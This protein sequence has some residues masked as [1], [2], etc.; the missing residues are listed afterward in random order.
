M[1]RKAAGY[2][3]EVAVVGGGPAGLIAAVALAAAGAETVLIAPSPGPDRRTTALLD[4]SVKALTAL[5]VWEGLA[6]RASAL[7]VLRLVDATRRLIRA[8]EVAFDCA[9]LGLEAFGYNIEN[10]ILRDGLFAAARA[11]KRLRRVDAAVTEVAPDDT[12]VMLRSGA[13]DER[14]RLLVAADGRDSF[15]RKAA[16]IATSGRKLPQSALAL[17][18]RHSRPHDN[19]STEFHTESGPFTLVPLP[20]RRSSLVWVVR[21]EE[22]DTLMALDDMALGGEVERR[23]HSI[24]GKMQVEAG[25]GV[26]PLA[27][28]I[29]ERFAARRIVLVGEAGHVLPPIGAQGLNLGIRDAALI[30]ELVAD[31]RRDGA[32]V[33]DVCAEYDRRRQSDVRSRAIAVDMFG[34]SLLTDFLPVHALRGLG[35]ALAAR[36]GPVRRLLMREGLGERADAPR[37]VR[38]EAL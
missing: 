26:F 5:D 4:G 30:A 28:A 33:G 34:R 19:I 1:V 13:G 16:G 36:V 37:L 7:K 8:P 35:L 22:A 24:L 14:V 2:T 11:T 18:L 38:G 31:A 20:G 9:E 29:A 10:E 12:G 3:A 15:C 27:S 23:A 21:P 6:P 25:R 17:T 32:D